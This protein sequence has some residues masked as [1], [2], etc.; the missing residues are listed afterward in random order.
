[1]DIKPEQNDQDKK[2]TTMKNIILIIKYINGDL[3]TFRKLLDK[4][5]EEYP[6]TAVTRL[7]S[8][9]IT[10][11]AL[12]VNDLVDDNSEIQKISESCYILFI[13]NDKYTIGADLEDLHPGID[14]KINQ[15]IHRHNLLKQR[16][17]VLFAKLKEQKTEKQLNKDTDKIKVFSKYVRQRDSKV[18]NLHIDRDGLN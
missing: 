4:N 18:Y 6:L 2:A 12:N 11:F 17:G 1:M 8:K 13:G 16:Y 15:V 10:Q 9:K 5:L 14:D 3:V 7:L